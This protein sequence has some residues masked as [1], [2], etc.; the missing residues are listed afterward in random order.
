MSYSAYHNDDTWTPSF[1]DE[2]VSNASSVIVDA[3][4]GDQQ[5]IYDY[6]ATGNVAIGIG[7]M[8]TNEDFDTAV[9][10]SS[11]LSI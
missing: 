5:C 9:T 10:E 11:E 1:F 7:T 3:C 4:K 8:E 2:T 6:A